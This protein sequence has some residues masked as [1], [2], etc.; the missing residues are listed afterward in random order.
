MK[1]DPKNVPPAQM[2]Q[3][4]IGAIIPRPIA[5]VSSRFSNGNNNLA[6]FSFFN[7]VTASPPTLLFSAVN[8]R[9]GE[10]KDTV[11][12]IEVHGEFVVS[13]VSEDLCDAMVKTSASFDYGVSEFVECGVEHLAS[14]VVQPFR[15]AKSLV[16]FE[17]VLDRIVEVGSGP[18]GAQLVLG[19]IVCMHIHD[20]ILGADGLIDSIK[21]KAVGRMGGQDY[22]KTSDIFQIVR[23]S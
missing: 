15:V 1:I 6:P 20:E 17:C 7:G 21:L 22:V 12:N 19:T 2:Y 23:P 5:W 4:M 10:R 9:H 8:N 14:E 11:R 16:A 13:I 3:Y 18:M